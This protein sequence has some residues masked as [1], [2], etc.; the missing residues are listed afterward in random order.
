MKSIIHL[1]GRLLVV[2]SFTAFFPVPVLGQQEE[3]SSTEKEQNRAQKVALV[4]TSKGKVAFELWPNIAPNHVERFIALAESGF[5]DGKPFHKNTPG[6]MMVFGRQDGT[7]PL[8]HSTPIK[9]ELRGLR[10]VPGSVYLDHIQERFN[11]GTTEVGFSVQRLDT[12]DGKYTCFG[13]VIRG[14]S[15][16]RAISLS[17]ARLDPA[18]GQRLPPEEVLVNKVTI[19]NRSELDE[20]EPLNP[21]N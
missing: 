21:K 14:M 10:I 3:E 4:E 8:E 6:R 16:L 12:M 11:T 18:T 5:F 9:A 1:F 15:V 2:F 17:A 13:Q 19:L 7:A 20:R